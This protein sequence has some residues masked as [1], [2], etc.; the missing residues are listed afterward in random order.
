M[1]LITSK[2][3][4]INIEPSYILYEFDNYLFYTNKIENIN[5]NVDNNWVIIGDFILRNNDINLPNNLS[6]QELLNL[7][8]SK[9]K[10]S[11]ISH[12]KG[13][14]VIIHLFKSS[15]RVYSDWFGIRKFFY[16][17]INKK[18]IISSDLDMIS[19]SFPLK[20]TSE[21]IAIYSLTYHFVGGRTLFN[22]VFH[23]LPGQYIS[24]INGSLSFHNYWNPSSLLLH[25]R[26]NVNIKH[27]TELLIESIKNNLVKQ[28]T[29]SI[30]LS[31][32]G[33]ADTRNLL[34]V[35]LALGIHPHLY[36]YGNPAS[37]DCT[38]A[39]K[40]SKKLQLHHSIYDIQ[41]DEFSFE[42][43]AKRIIKLSGGL[44]SVHRVHR[45]L[46]VEMENKICDNMFLG[47]LGGEFVKGVS[48]DDYIIPAIL[49]ENWNNEFTPQIVKKYFIK[50]GLLTND[51]SIIAAICSFLKNQPFSNNSILER[52]HSTLCDITAHLHDAQDINL[53]ET[54]ID[55][56][57]TPFLDI[58]YLELLFSS[59]YCY[60]NN[61]TIKNEIL[62]KVNYPVFSSE[63]LRETYPPLLRFKYSREHRP[64]EVLFN[65]YYAAIVRVFRQ[66]TKRTF[67]SNFPLLEWMEKFVSMN[68]KEC[69]DYK[70]LCE[71]FDLDKLLNEFRNNRH[72]TNEAYWLKYTNP[73]MMKFIIEEFKN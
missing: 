5:P 39:L 13:N 51:S 12:I 9:Y 45:L 41:L 69:K 46:S 31:L 54:V 68:L 4:S 25:Q 64:D 23:N 60:P 35:F 66:R 62:K 40:I 27:L 48:E 24:F 19:Q 67:P 11:F 63:F 21:N 14:F 70:I 52:K 49:Y 1:W 71:S 6:K 16:S 61:E 22:D 55:N 47:T 36:T 2:D 32:T 50:K 17:S 10:D 42:K 43:N 53:Y 34:S 58:D 18:I 3:L 56:V 28:D 57:Y 38:K 44:A 73:I 26:K 7:L 30:S 37:D 15:F 8:C 29:K 65:K 59:K 20:P 33:G 72:Q